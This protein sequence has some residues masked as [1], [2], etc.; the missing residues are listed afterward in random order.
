[1]GNRIRVVVTYRVGGATN[2]ES[3][4]LTSDYPVLEARRGDSK[5]KFDPAAVSRSVVEGDK[6]R[7][8][9]ARVTATD[10]HGAVNY[11]LVDPTVGDA[12]KF[13]INQKTGQI[14]TKVKLD[15]DADAG[16]ASNCTVKNT[17][18]VTVRAT[19]ASGAPTS[20][21]APNLDATVTIKITDVDEKPTFTETA[22]TA[23]S[24][25]TITR[26][27]NM[28]MLADTGSEAAVTYAAE[29]P[30]G[31]HV[32]LTL[33]GPDSAKFSLSTTGV[34]SFKE[35]PDYENPADQNKDN[36]YQ[37]TVRASDGTM[38]ADRMVSVRVTP[39]NEDPEIVLGGLLISGRDSVNV[40]ENTTAVETYELAG[41]NKA[42]ANWTLSGD[43]AGH[44]RVTSGALTFASAPNFETPAS[45]DRDNVY[46][47]TLTANDGTYMDTH[48]VEVTVTNAEE[49]G[50]V[51]LT[52]GGSPLLVGEVVTAA[53]TD[54]DGGVTGDTWQ[55]SRGD[56]ADGFGATVI[57]GA[58]S[59]TYTVDAADEG[60]YLTASVT[61]TDGYGADSA[62]ATTSETVTSNREPEFPAATDTRDVAE[63]SAAGTA[64]G[65]P[66]T[67]T[68]A[69]TGDTL[70]YSLSGTD[71]AAF[72]IDSGTGQI[73]VG[74]S[75]TLDYETKTSYSVTVTATDP[76]GSTDS[77]DVTINVTNVGLNEAY[78]VDDSGVIERDEVLMAI[79]DY[80]D[81]GTP[82]KD[83]VLRLI[84]LYLG[85]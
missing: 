79:D 82:D 41:P 21:T 49:D 68:D 47:V 83:E 75:T 53:L 11:V 74:A 3:A 15:F 38:H 17:C 70:T 54:P 48:D 1:M 36:V 56:M 42:M 23:L 44:F 18:S 61:Y 6:D 60:M 43:D 69:D 58:T 64:V 24:P 10:G 12:A 19:D 72:D 32:N 73:S 50:T 40:V 20:A 77:V 46:E 55:W 59:A 13:N 63:N 35:K 67:A 7:N 78:D 30:E 16:A 34:L 65:M 81:T 85:D 52:H 33:L 71:A 37:V 26:A 4:S 25:K 76:D 84:D 62:D 29:D 27:E 8:V 31:L 66:V 2:Q 9:G 51:T 22:G 28:T 5:L 14:T 39:V 45:A 80:L 57:D